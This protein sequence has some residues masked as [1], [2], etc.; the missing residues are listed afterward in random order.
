MSKEWNS[1]KICKAINMTLKNKVD[2][3]TIKSGHTID[4]E[5]NCSLLRL[6]DLFSDYKKIVSTPQ[7]Q[8]HLIAQRLWWK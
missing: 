7:G 5:V 4:L 3:N 2:L 6:H 8:G 1:L